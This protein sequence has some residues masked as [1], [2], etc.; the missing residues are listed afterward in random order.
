[1]EKIV[2]KLEDLFSKPIEGNANAVNVYIPINKIHNI[3]VRACLFTLLQPNT[4]TIHLTI[5]SDKIFEDHDANTNYRMY[6]KIIFDSRKSTDTLCGAVSKCVEI[7]K[8][9]KLNKYTGKFYYDEEQYDDIDSAFIELIGNVEHVEYT[10]NECCV[11]TEKTRNKT[12]CGHSI[13]IECINRLYY[14]V[15]EDEISCPLCR[16]N[17]ICNYH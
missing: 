9:L 5:E 17:I 13:C 4:K 1:M 3:S 7:I 16:E 6:G 8:N 2:K 12:C 10:S 14:D 15:E 11:C